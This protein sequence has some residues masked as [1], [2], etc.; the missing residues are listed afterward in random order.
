MAD[1]VQIADAELVVYWRERAEKAERELA[2]AR[3]DPRR[4]A[5]EQRIRKLWTR[6]E[7]EQR[8][9]REAADEA[10]EVLEFKAKGGR[11]R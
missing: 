1:Y 7:V 5:T 4:I 6:V 8:L 10:Q 9:A 3:A 2:Q 11:R